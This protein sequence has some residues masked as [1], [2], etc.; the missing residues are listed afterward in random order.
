MHQEYYVGF[1]VSSAASAGAV[2]I[3]NIKLDDNPSPPPKIGYGLPG[4]DISAYIDEADPPITVLANYKVPGLIHRTYSVATTTNI[5]GINGDFLWD[6]ETS[7]PWLSVTK[8]VPEPTLQG[9]NFTPP[10]PRQE[11]T[12]TLTVDPSGLAP[13]V[14][15]GEITFYGIL[16]N[17][18]FPPPSSG[19]IATNEPLVVPVLLRITDAGGKTGPQSIE[20]SFG[21]LTVPGSP[22]EFA[23]PQTGDPIAVL[24]VTSGQIDNMTIRAFPN[25]LPQNLA[26]LVYVKRY[27][28][29][30][31]A[32]S[33]WTGDIGFTYSDHEANMIADPMQ[34]RGVRQPVSLGPWEDPI[35]GTS[36]TS[37]PAMNTVTV[38]DLNEHNV[39]GNIALAHPYMILSK[40]D[41]IPGTFG[42]E[43]NYPN[44]FGVSTGTFSTTIA[45][46]VAD[47][48]H[49]RLAVYNTLGV[50]VA[51]LVDGVMAPGRYEV[52]FDARGLDSGTYMYR[53]MSGDFV[54]TRMMTLSK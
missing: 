10:R 6:V 9:Y 28:Q 40:N 29:I 30:E 23:D 46:A 19:L 44:P 25:Q 35:S 8:S 38:H 16:F 18:D 21:P 31:H 5:Y 1:R 22:Y 2:V 47:E 4:A 49:V 26:R 53:M 32:G 43:R 50:E 27:W 24:N 42:L 20:A 13:G 36:S 12:F 17:D 37:D 34:L 3:D 33:G 15:S 51:V 54:Q 45:F 39:G 41:G 52:P 11:Q 48:R 7:T 14:H